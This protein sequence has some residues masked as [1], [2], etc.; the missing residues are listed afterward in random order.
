MSPSPS[1]E[2]GF[3]TSPVGNI[4]CG[5]V[6]KDKCQSFCNTVTDHKLLPLPIA[7]D[8]LFRRTWLVIKNSRKINTQDGALMPI[9]LTLECNCCKCGPP[10]GPY[11]M[12]FF[13]QRTG[14]NSRQLKKKGKL[15]RTNTKKCQ[16]DKNNP[17]WWEH[18]MTWQRWPW[19][20]CR[21]PRRC[22][23]RIILPTNVHHVRK[24]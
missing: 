7:K 22:R 10:T 16:R 6:Q 5:K 24:S 4:S 20:A 18:R 14:S 2:N 15:C 23:R 1:I 8:L 21:K 9:L 3:A 19:Q 13:L 11:G 17:P 12:Q